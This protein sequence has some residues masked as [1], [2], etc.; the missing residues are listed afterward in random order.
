MWVA[1][2]WAV[3]DE[4]NAVKLQVRLKEEPSATY[5]AS[6]RATVE[7]QFRINFK[8]WSGGARSSVERVPE[9]QAA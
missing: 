2:A 6:L 3:D 1:S 9:R 8:K 5:M 4:G 7:A